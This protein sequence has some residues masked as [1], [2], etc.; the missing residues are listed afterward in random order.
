MTEPLPQYKMPDYKEPNT[1][2][3]DLSS[4]VEIQPYDINP[5]AFLGSPT[6]VKTTLPPEQMKR[7]SSGANS[8]N[9]EPFV[10]SL[11][12]FINDEPS[13]STTGDR[14]E[15]SN[16]KKNWDEM[17][18][19]PKKYDMSNNV[20]NPYGYGYVPSLEE[21]RN[22]DSLDLY[23]QENATFFIGAITG[24]SLIVLGI[25]LAANSPAVTE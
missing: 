18:K 3:N 1:N 16:L 10:E 23:Q 11:V 24:V 13:L 9:T 21:T 2:P 4:W 12:S 17:T 15:G 14:I 7:T 22:A 6:T 8:S 5:P 20:V 19:D 25:L